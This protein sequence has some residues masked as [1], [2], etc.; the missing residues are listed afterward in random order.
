MRTNV[1]AMM[2][3]MAA[4]AVMLGR[5]VAVTKEA[6]VEADIVEAVPSIVISWKGLAYG[7]VWIG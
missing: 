4:V 1:S 5:K 6:V 3:P 7:E 2:E